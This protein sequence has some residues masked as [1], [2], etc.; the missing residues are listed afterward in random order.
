M[1]EA[2]PLS[3]VDPGFVYEVVALKID[4]NT[5]VD[6]KVVGWVFFDIQVNKEYWAMTNWWEDGAAET[7]KRKPGVGKA[8]VVRF[9]PIAS[10]GTIGYPQGDSHEERRKH[11]FANRALGKGGVQYT[12]T[13]EAV[14]I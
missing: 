5:I 4:S 14:K 7:W 12:H 13:I 2:E 9:N 8:T 1:I 6:F 3:Q 11:F 10:F